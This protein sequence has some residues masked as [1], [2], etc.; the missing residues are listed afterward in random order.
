VT[1]GRKPAGAIALHETKR[2][3]LKELAPATYNP[4]KIDDEALAALSSS[5]EEFGLVQ[6]IVWNK[7]SGRVVGGH[8]RIRVL[9]SRGMTEADVLVVDLDEAKEKALNVVL[10]SKAVAGKYTDALDDLLAE[11]E[12]G[13]GDLYGDLRLDELE[14]S[15]AG[16]PPRVVEVEDVGDEFWIAVRGPLAMQADALDLLRAKL[17]GIEGVEVNLGIVKR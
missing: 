7:R 4:R 10:N 13:V 9:E 14:K 12:T 16:L 5:L 1:K 11:I 3:P 2:M 15:D 6:P 17:E 8:Q